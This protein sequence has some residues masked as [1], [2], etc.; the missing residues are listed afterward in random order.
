MIPATQKQN[1]EAVARELMS[2]AEFAKW[3]AA[4]QANL[5]LRLFDKSARTEQQAREE[6]V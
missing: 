5:W 6:M 1:A 4:R 2:E 3:Q